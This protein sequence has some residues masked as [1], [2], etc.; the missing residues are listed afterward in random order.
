MREV[1]RGQVV[2]LPGSAV[3]WASGV[4]H[5]A[6]ASALSHVDT[7]MTVVHSGAIGGT[8]PLNVSPVHGRADLQ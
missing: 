7:V 1:H 3:G 6:H 8:D 4:S 2:A 5:T